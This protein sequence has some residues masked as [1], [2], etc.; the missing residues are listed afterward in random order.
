MKKT[1]LLI[2]FV[3]TLSVCQAANMHDVAVS[4]TVDKVQP[5][6][7][8]VLWPD[9]A[10][11]K[12]SNYGNTFALEYSYCKY[13]D[14]VT[15]KGSDGKIQYD[16]SSLESTLNAIKGRGH[17]AILR[18]WFEYPGE[19]PDGKTIGVTA[20][21]AYI[22]ALSGYK[23]TSYTG[24]EGKCYY[25]DWSN[26]ELKWFAKQF[27][28]D[29]AAKYDKDPRI[30]IMEI[31]FGHWG[32]YH[33]SDGPSLRLGVN[34][35][36]K[37]YQEEFLLHVAA[38]F[39]Q[40]PWCISVDAAET[41]Q[42]SVTE[43]NSLKNLHFG[44]FDD[45]FMCNGHDK[46]STGGEKGYNE[47]N[48]DAIGKNRY[49]F[50]ACGGEISYYKS[51][52]QKNFLNPAGMY[53]MVWET[54]VAKYHLTFMI[55]NDAIGGQYATTTRF[56]EG[57]MACGYH[58]A[59]TACKTDG[60]VTEVTVKN[61]GVAPI[62]KDA[63]MCIGSTRAT[64]SL[65]GLQPGSSQT[66]TINAGLANGN[67]LKIACDYIYSTQEIQ[68][69]ANLSGSSDP[70]PVIDPIIDPTPTPGGNVIFSWQMSGTSA[71]GSGT[72]L[73]A[74]GGVVVTAT[75]DKEK[76]FTVEN[77]AYAKGTPDE[78][79][80]LDGKGLKI[81]ANA[82]SIKISLTDGNFQ[83][84]DTIYICGYN[85]WTISMTS[86]NDGDV[87]AS[88]A[89]GTSKTD[90]QTAFVVLNQSCN[91]LY[92][93]RATGSGTGVSAIRVVRPESSVSTA[94]EFTHH[95]PIVH[96]FIRNG[97]LMILHD[98]KMYNAIGRRY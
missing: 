32:E 94:L 91:E 58:F 97:Q 20:V 62:Y 7:G 84:G 43:R 1:L 25:A 98:G 66:Y 4:R 72:T 29:F 10:S 33:I 22:K 9:L 28:T 19:Q 39:D 74:T 70:G 55:A 76:S 64:A 3:L 11:E 13:S 88:L 93:K 57:S 35:P 5:M 2:S 86:A 16:W 92:F 68:F 71:P 52:D 96:K 21:P 14:V 6:T 89:T 8:L 31:G 42:S 46:G 75:S 85:A 26:S 78:M 34:F 80:A 24:D 81:G 44:V 77:A 50:S 87:A 30:A 95:A 18:F 51:S 41:D 73:T 17:Q 38:Q 49:Q 65:K 36:S 90:Y 40:M 82:L 15:G 23:E 60:S 45:S 59:V 67:D 27:Y 61:N 47:E 12:K 48:W 63:Y 56:K 69:D 79:K 83:S 53:N 37:D 54:E